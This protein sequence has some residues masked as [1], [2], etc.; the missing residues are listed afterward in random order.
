MRVSSEEKERSRARIVEAAGRMF[1]EQ[2][3][4]GA[5][6][7]D[8]MAAAGMTHGGF[9]R[10]FAD[11]DDLLVAALAEAFE[12]FAAPMVGV[13]PEEGAER[14]AAFRRAYLSA[15]HCGA[16]GQ[17]CPAAA[18]G[19]EIARSGAPVRAAFAAGLERIVGAMAQGAGGDARAEALR[20]VAMMLGAVVIA[21]AAGGDLAEEV[22]AA[23]G[24]E[25]A[26]A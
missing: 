20:Q 10:H 13:P 25:G 5:S 9:Y 11:K 8:I 7:G 12:R 1:R 23:C 14:V 15:E 24:A 4:A 16:P 26:A 17:G 6:V 22:L 19:P 2:G 18:L 3:I 21:R